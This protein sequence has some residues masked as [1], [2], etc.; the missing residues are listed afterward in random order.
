VKKLND[1][2]FET[3]AHSYEDDKETMADI[4]AIRERRKQIR[5]HERGREWTEE[6]Y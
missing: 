2:E 5:R 1:K 4:E 3:Y 6:H